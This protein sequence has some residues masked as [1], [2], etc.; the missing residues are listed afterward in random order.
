MNTP[1]RVTYSAA[2]G[3][4]VAMALVALGC[5]KNLPTSE[6]LPPANPASTDASAGSWRMIVVAGPGQFPV[7]PPA[8]TSSDT[9]QAELD[10]IKTGQANIT[11]AQRQSIDYWSGGGVL[12]WNQIM[13]ELVARYNLPPAPRDDGSYVFPDA[14]NPF[15][16]PQFPFANP[17]YAVRAYSYV[18]V[19][20][21]EALKVAWSYKYQYNRPVPHR[22]DSSIRA[23]MPASE[24][25]A[26]PSEDAVVSGVSTELLR[27]MFPAA[28][29]E[30]TRKAGEQREAVLLS[31]RAAA[32]DISA[33]LALGRAVAAVFVTR[34][35]ADG[36]GAA[37]GTPA[38]WQA[39]ADGAAARGE[40][41][42]KSLES[43][44]R[45]P[46]LPSFGK[47]R[48]WMMTPTDIVNERPAPPPSTSSAQMA[49]EVAEVRQVLEKLTREQLAIALN[50][51]DG[52]STYTPPGHWNAIAAEYIR[53]ARFS[54]VRA[55]RAFALLNMAE[56][57]AGVGCWDAK[58][59]YF[60]PRPSQLDPRIK[61]SIG[62]PNFPSYTSGHSTFSAAAATVLSYLFASGA[63]SFEAMMDEAAIS[64]LY[65]GI[66]YRSDI[67]VGKQHGGRIGA[68]T[69]SFA[70]QDGADN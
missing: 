64:R 22:V 36:M 10:A 65:G 41:P 66:H 58:F 17:P 43:P 14:N 29:E 69:V 32:S 20:Q 50:W 47:V 23:L 31:G 27:L 48:A 34:A 5:S 56:H 59:T 2:V 33:G 68:Y 67:E 3:T 19:A 7:A 44:P 15:A 70:R 16:D 49:Q 63:A 26:Y 21:F 60:N 13:R 30:I 57:D 37:V 46:M 39:L 25:P 24:L 4:L 1:C 45:P 6:Q 40:I 35:S 28:A 61:T 38:Q 52:V 54:E 18:A 42:W 8:P 51:N 12:R 62:L 9:Y 11:V 53:D 55:A